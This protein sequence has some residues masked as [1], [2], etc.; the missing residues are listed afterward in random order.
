MLSILAAVFVPVGFIPGIV[1]RLYQQFAITIAISV[2]ISAFV[3]LSLTPALC[4]LILKPHKLDEKSKGLDKFFFRFNQWF[5]RVNSK[6]R[7]GVDRSIKNSKFVII[8]LVCIVVGVV[9]LFEKK[10]TGFIPTEDEGRIYVTYDLPEASSTV[11]SVTVLHQMMKTLD[12]I[13]EVGH[14]AALGGLN[15]VSF[16]SKS[17]SGTIFVQLKP[18]DDRK[19]TSLDLVGVIQKKFARYKEASVVVIRPP[20]VPGLGRQWFRVYP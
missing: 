16:A 15:A 20:A 5:G 10:P 9:L 1:G 12:S 2:L 13:P 3:A 11:R 18:W 7:N 17:N 19:L 4:T 14:Y 8:I 6:Y